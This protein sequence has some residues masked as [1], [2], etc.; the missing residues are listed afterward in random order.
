MFARTG[1][2]RWLKGSRWRAEFGSWRQKA[3]SQQDT[4]GAVMDDGD[5]LFVSISNTQSRIIMQLGQLS[6]RL[7]TPRR[8]R[9]VQG[10]RN[11]YRKLA[12]AH[13]MKSTLLNQFITCTIGLNESN[14]N[15]YGD[16]NQVIASN[17][18]IIQGLQLSH[19]SACVKNDSDAILDQCPQRDMEKHAVE[20]PLSVPFFHLLTA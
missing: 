8:N 14:Q 4:G 12:T 2:T 20:A 7:R 19:L 3:A 16:S 6:S 13:E 15:E 9:S 17:L 18:I 1:E 5:S 10:W 11:G